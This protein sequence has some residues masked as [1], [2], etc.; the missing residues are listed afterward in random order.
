[1]KEESRKQIVYKSTKIEIGEFNDSTEYIVT[2]SP[3]A[4]II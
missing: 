1:M 3:Y 4:R 2:H